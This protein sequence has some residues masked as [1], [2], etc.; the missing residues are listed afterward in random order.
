MI[1]C[2]HIYGSPVLWLGIISPP[3]I[4]VRWLVVSPD[5]RWR[6]QEPRACAKRMHDAHWRFIDRND[7]RSKTWPRAWTVIG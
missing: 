2:D 3:V 1:P 7:A 6:R 4:S 5:V